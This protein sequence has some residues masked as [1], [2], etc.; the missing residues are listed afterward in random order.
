MESS[1]EPGRTPLS[2][3]LCLWRGSGVSNL[4]Q[5]LYRYDTWQD[6]HKWLV[7][8]G[9]SHLALMQQVVGDPLGESVVKVISSGDVKIFSQSRV[10]FLILDK[11]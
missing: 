8:T 11:P 7:P 1:A 5:W 10:N 3:P 4:I 6:G 2:A 9:V